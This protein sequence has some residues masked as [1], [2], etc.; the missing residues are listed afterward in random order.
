MVKRYTGLGWAVG[1][2]LCVAGGVAAQSTC[3]VQTASSST[4]LVVNTE[5]EASAGTVLHGPWP[6][7]ATRFRNCKPGEP[8]Q[9]QIKPMMPGLTYVRDVVIDGLTYPA[10]GWNATSSL[11]ILGIQVYSGSGLGIWR[12]PLKIDKTSQQ[13]I[14]AG[15]TGEF[16]VTLRVGL[17]ARGGTIIKETQALGVVETS[18]LNDPSAVVSNSG[19]VEVNP[20]VDS[21]R[22]RAD[23]AGVILDPARQPELQ[24]PGDTAG[25]EPLPA[26]VRCS[27]DG[28]VAEVG[29]DDA[30][31]MGNTSSVLTPAAGT[32]ATGVGL[33]ILRNGVPLPMGSRWMFTDGATWTDQGLSARYIRTSD[34][35]SAGDIVGEAIITA[36]MK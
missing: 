31:D 25:E 11:V 21:C 35:L 20:A 23:G 9:L 19:S 29:I 28:V 18:L 8:L 7:G 5:N 10:Y 27:R 33:Q 16:A 3:A 30:L 2:T 12:F 36:T 1:L 15:P 4:D 22:V 32:S 14:L 26:R 34:A 24:R 6:G 13:G 17:V